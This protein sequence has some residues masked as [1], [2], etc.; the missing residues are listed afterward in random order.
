MNSKRS[1]SKTIYMRIGRIFWTKWKVA[2]TI[3][4][5][6]DG[7]GVF[8]E[9]WVTGQKVVL[10]TGL[11]TTDMAQEIADQQNKQHAKRRKSKLRPIQ[12]G[13]SGERSSEVRP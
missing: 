8:R 9:N 13:L 2:R 12:G 6:K 7:W 10:E 11:P 5:Y 3:W 1:P 4:P